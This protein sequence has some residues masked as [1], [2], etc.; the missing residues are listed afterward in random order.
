[1]K[2]AVEIQTGPIEDET[3]ARIAMVRPIVRATLF[4]LSIERV[5]RF[6]GFPEITLH[7]LAREWRE[8]DGDCGICFEYAI[9]DAIERR[10]PLLRP[11]I[12]EVLESQCRIKGSVRSILFGAEKGARLELL[13][14]NPDLLTPESRLLVSSRG[15]PVKL[16]THLDRVKRAFSVPHERERL[17]RSIRGLWRADLFVGAPAED[18]WV[19]TTLK[20]NPAHLEGAPGIRIGIYPERRR[21]EAPSFDDEKNLVLCPVPYDGG[22]M[23]LFYSAFVLVK[24]FLGRDARVPPPVELLGSADRYVA[25]L[26]E[27]RRAFPVLDVLDA[28]ERLAQPGL[29]M[30]SGAGDPYSIS[31]TSAVA[32][33][34]RPTE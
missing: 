23:E 21:G 28:L 9:H 12:E 17:P 7:D 25:K 1:M 34:A 3:R 8:G 20:I 24:T 13:E 33:V 27:E 6:G 32:P 2:L 31:A 5:E 15:R 30:S 19:A 22:F 14:S 29:L 10:D 26:L 18:R 4:A 11:R 16:K